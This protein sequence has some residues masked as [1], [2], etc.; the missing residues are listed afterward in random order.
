MVFVPKANRSWA[1]LCHEI[2]HKTEPK[3]MWSFKTFLVCRNICSDNNL[4]CHILHWAPRQVITTGGAPEVVN[5]NPNWTLVTL[6]SSSTLTIHAVLIYVS[7]VQIK[8][9]FSGCK[10]SSMCLWVSLFPHPGECIICVWVCV[11]KRSW[12]G[13]RNHHVPGCLE[14][15]AR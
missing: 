11:W 14:P 1:Q 8:L 7:N 4:L 15:A 3:E 5:R 6:F 10:S 13:L 2:K 9:P 12:L